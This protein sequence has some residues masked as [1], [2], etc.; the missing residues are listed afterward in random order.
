MPAPPI[1]RPG[2]AIDGHWPIMNFHTQDRQEHVI[3]SPSLSSRVNSAKDLVAR[4]IRSF[5]L[6]RM[7]GP[8][9]MVENHHRRCRHICA[10]YDSA[11]AV[12]GGAVLSTLVLPVVIGILLLLRRSQVS[13]V[14]QHEEG[15]RAASTTAV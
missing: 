1:Y 13:A 6:L 4:R 10:A 14:S 3:L 11:L 8:V 5:A 15:S 7:T 12:Y 2:E 9:V